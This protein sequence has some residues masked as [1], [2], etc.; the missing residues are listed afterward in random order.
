MSTRSGSFRRWPLR[1]RHRF[2]VA[3]RKLEIWAG[4]LGIFACLFLTTDNVDA[5]GSQEDRIPPL[6]PPRGPLPPDFWEQYGVWVLAGGV[7]ALLLAGLGLWL[8][9]RPKPPVIIP[10]QEEARSALTALR[11]L[12]ET[13]G[14][15]SR[16][17]QVLRHYFGAAFSLAKGE[18]TT[19]EFCRAID[20]APEP[21]PQLKGKVKAFLRECDER[22]FSPGQGTAPMGAAA[23]ALNLVAEGEARRAQL[24]S[25]K[26]R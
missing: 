8:I 11:E 19:A 24:R 26:Q 13:G 7:F 5:A 1:A 6:Q 16:I 22:K 12:P 15:L 10:P 2:P 17:S 21:E 18:M 23:Q 14:V 3:L 9:L 20:D 25:E 4:E